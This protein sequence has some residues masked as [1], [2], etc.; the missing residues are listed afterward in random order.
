[1]RLTTLVAAALSPGSVVWVAQVR[2]VLQW[3]EQ[4]RMDRRGDL[5]A[6]PSSVE[7]VERSYAEQGRAVLAYIAGAE[8]ADTEIC[9]DAV[10]VAGM[11]AVDLAADTLVAVVQA[12]EVPVDTDSRASGCKISRATLVTQD[13]CHQSSGPAVAECAV[14][15]EAVAVQWADHSDSL[16]VVAADT[17]EMNASAASHIRSVNDAA[18]ERSAG[19]VVSGLA[20]AAAAVHLW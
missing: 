20:K 7:A 2:A 18:I 10:A 6:A 1:M 5:G 9:T 3:A 17:N 15:E 14:V 19:S 8:V 4:R 13:F 12:L 11:L 16:L